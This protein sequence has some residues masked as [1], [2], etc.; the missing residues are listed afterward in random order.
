MSKLFYG[1]FN[2]GCCALGTTME[3][4][5]NQ[6][7]FVAMVARKLKFGHG[8]GGLLQGGLVSGGSEGPEPPASTSG[9]SQNVESTSGKSRKI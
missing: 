2:N 6:G 3:F 1:C 4:V 5:A 9:R 8:Y 7:L